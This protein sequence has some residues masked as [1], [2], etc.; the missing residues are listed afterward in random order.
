MIIQDLHQTH[1]H[2]I[3]GEQLLGILL[4]GSVVVFLSQPL[5]P[6]RQVLG[7]LDHIPTAER[8]EQVPAV[9]LRVAGAVDDSHLKREN[10][11]DVL[12]VPHQTGSC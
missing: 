5:H 11:V 6:P 4:R 12:R 8:S 3:H 2:I 1:R 10:H 9:A 7:C